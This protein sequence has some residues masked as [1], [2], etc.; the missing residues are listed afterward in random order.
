MAAPLSSG[1]STV[2]DAGVN[3]VKVSPVVDLAYISKNRK[4]TDSVTCSDVVSVIFKPSAN[5]NSDGLGGG[6]NSATYNSEDLN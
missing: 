2:L 6:F 4:L 5:F 3:Y 1:K